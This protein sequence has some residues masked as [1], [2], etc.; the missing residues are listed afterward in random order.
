MK[1]ALSLALVSWPPF[2]ARSNKAGLTMQGKDKVWV[3]RRIAIG[4]LFPFCEFP[5]AMPIVL[6]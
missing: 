6:Y 1:E 3:I 4:L 5:E 2:L